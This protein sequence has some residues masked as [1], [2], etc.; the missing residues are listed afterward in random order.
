MAVITISNQKGGQAK[1]TSAINIAACL[2]VR[3]LLVD[4]DPQGG[5]AVSLGHDPDNLNTTVYDCL[6]ERA[7]ASDAILPTAFGFD[8]LPANVDLAEAELALAATPGREFALKRALAPIVSEYHTILIDTPPTLGLL[9]LNAFAA[10][11][12]VLIPISTQLLS[13]RGLSTLMDTID[14]LRRYS[15]NPELSVLGLLPTRHDSRT[16]HA[17]Q[18]LDYLG[19]FAIE[20]HLRVFPP[21]RSTVRFDE[22]IN[23]RTPFVLLYPEDAATSAYEEVARACQEIA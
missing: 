21:V 20:N 22:A 3:T 4:L 18:V 13:L 12:A 6:T 5:C 8:L 14:K 23:E 11:D 7:K 2:G 10:S 15:I 9:T 1:T 19:N 17:R 16:T